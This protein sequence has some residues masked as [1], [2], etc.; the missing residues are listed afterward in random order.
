MARAQGAAGRRWNRA[1]AAAAITGGPA[2]NAQRLERPALCRLDA[3]PMGRFFAVP[4]DGDE[5]A[6]LEA[7][8]LLRMLRL[9]QPAYARVPLAETGPGWVAGRA[10]AFGGAQVFDLYRWTAETELLADRAQVHALSPAGSGWS[11]RS[12]RDEVSAGTGSSNPGAAA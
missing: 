11:R 4:V 3:P 5:A 10:E 2:L 12:R 6:R 1:G 7:D 8:A 9:G